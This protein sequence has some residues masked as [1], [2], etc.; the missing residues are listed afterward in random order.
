MS[1]IGLSVLMQTSHQEM[2]DLI[3]TSEQIG[4]LWAYLSTL[5]EGGLEEPWEDVA[6]VGGD[7]MGG[8]ST[9]FD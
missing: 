5:R 9:H 3:V 6:L 2:P 8:I 4:D 1:R 7:Q